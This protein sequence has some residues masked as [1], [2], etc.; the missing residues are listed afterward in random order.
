[1]HTN[2]LDM[3]AQSGQLAP[4]PV[5]LDLAEPQGAHI[6]REDRLRH[7]TV[8]GGTPQPSQQFA[9][10]GSQARLTHS[11][12]GPIPH[13]THPRSLHTETRT[14]VLT[15]STGLASIR[16]DLNRVR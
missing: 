10:R 11:A 7:D 8:H 1:M 4:Q 9:Q 16:S 2:V 5:P 6:L 12:D 14:G 15:M 3:Q 13:A